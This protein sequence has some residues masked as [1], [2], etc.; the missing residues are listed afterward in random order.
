VFVLTRSG[1]HRTRV[2]GKGA[3]GVLELNGGMMDVEFAKLGI[4]PLQDGIAF[5]WRHVLNQYVTT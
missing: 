1:C 2:F 3:L 4:H 5:R